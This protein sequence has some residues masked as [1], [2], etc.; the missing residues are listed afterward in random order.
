MLIM[1]TNV[2]FL[3]TANSARSLMAEAIF[4]QFAGDDFE[5]ASAGTEPTQPEP[6]A[7]AALE[8]LGV[9]TDGLHSKALDEINLNSFDY[10]I[11]LCDRAR[12]ECQT[13]CGDQHFIAWDFPDPVTSKKSDAFK[14]TAHELSERIKMLLLILRKKSDRPQ[15][16]DAPH[17][18]FKIMADPL[19]LKMILM[20]QYHGELCVCQFV[21]A[22]GMSQPKVSRHLAQLR[23]YGLL[24]DRKD[25]RW[26]YYRINPALQDWM[27]TMIK[28]TAAY[29]ASLI[30]QQVKDVDNG[31]V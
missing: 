12:T 11:S 4:R 20:L 18:F 14:K 2:L 8:H 16:F 17:E 13:L 23:E 25:Q 27:A 3:C 21:D 15:L 10:V 29:H 6:G 28:T 26:V 24:A 7:L 31:C 5:V 1:T 9:E 30:P 19:R 22:T